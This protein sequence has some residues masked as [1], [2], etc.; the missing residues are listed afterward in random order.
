MDVEDMNF[1][2]VEEVIEEIGDLQSEQNLKL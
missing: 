1:E 2:G